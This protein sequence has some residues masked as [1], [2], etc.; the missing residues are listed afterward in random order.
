MKT[1]LLPILLFLASFSLE[2]SEPAINLASEDFVRRHLDS[3]RSGGITKI[4][5]YLHAKDIESFKQVMTPKLQA[6]RDA[7]EPN[8]ISPDRPHYTTLWEEQNPKEFMVSYLAMREVANMAI[9]FK[10]LDYQI[11]GSIKEQGI[12]HYLVRQK[13]SIEGKESDFLEVVSTS[14]E[15]ETLGLLLPY[16][17]SFAMSSN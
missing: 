13:I 1:L 15:G 6:Q 17:L 3:R 4:V 14:V 16:D 12:N 2:A 7:V 11:L 10:F 9:D 5:D 8:E